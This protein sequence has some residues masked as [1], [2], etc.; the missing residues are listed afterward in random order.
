[1][2]DSLDLVTEDGGASRGAATTRGRQPGKR[3][4]LLLLAGRLC[5]EGTG[6]K[7]GPATPAAIKVD[8]ASREKRA[9]ERRLRETAREQDQEMAETWRTVRGFRGVRSG[10]RFSKSKTGL[11]STT[12]PSTMLG[13][14]EEDRRLPRVGG[15]I[16]H[17]ESPPERDQG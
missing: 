7:L 13:Q 5:W 8:E 16:A 9:A 2:A 11:A 4:F 15:V 3:R 14:L 10:F 1:V 17:E 6:R 12:R